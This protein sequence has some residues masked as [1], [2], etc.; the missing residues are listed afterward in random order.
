MDIRRA[1]SEPAYF[2][3]H[4]LIDRDGTP[5]PLGS[6]IE[7]WQKKDFEALDP[8]WMKITRRD[9]PAAPYQRAYLERARGHSKTTDLAVMCSYVL[10]ASKS[11]IFGVAGA[12]D[13]T[14]A[15][16][17]NDTI[18]SLIQLNPWL[19]GELLEA[20]SH[21]VINKH[22]RSKLEI[23][24]SDVGSS[25]G[26]TPDFII[27]DELVHWKKEGFWESMAS[28]AGKRRDCV[29]VVITNAGLGIGITWQWRVREKFRK[30]DTW[31]FSRLDGPVASWMTEERLDEQRKLLSESAYKR[32]WLNIWASDIGGLSAEDIR[33]CTVL[34]GPQYEFRHDRSP[35]IAGLDLG[36]RHD[37]SAFVVL[38]SDVMRQ[39]TELVMSKSWKPP[40]GGEIKI[41]KVESEVLEAQ[42]RFHLDAVIYDPHQAVHLAQRLRDRGVNMIEMPF[43]PRNCDL[44]ATELLKA[45]SNRL[46]GLYDDQELLHDLLRLQIVERQSGFK[47]QATRDETGHCDRAVALSMV[48]PYGISWT[49]ERLEEM[50]ETQG[51]EIIY[52]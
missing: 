50:H 33:A 16:L 46:I 30:S 41:E 49:R 27:A 15:K 34:D 11:K 23:M 38:C 3:E 36:I 7:P 12:S 52:V 28:S 18:G 14:Q 44:M 21:D 2:R 20:H 43:T 47:L 22:T 39:R 4:L 13:R 10:F 25:F 5:T 19:G 51:D 48:L 35:Y 40:V 8:A 45:F 17:L 9:L 42:R 24:A 1:R 29:L 31:Y 32:L 26:V 6:C 37:H